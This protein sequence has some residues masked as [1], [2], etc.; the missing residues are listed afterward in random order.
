MCGLCVVTARRYLL[1]VCSCIVCAKNS[2]AFFDFAS[3]L[4]FCYAG[5]QIPIRYGDDG[6]NEN[7]GR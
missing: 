4:Q 1:C 3:R 5:H 7:Q 2:Y 6:D